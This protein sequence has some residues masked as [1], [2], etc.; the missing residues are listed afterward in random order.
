[1]QSAYWVWIVSR[2]LGKGNNNKGTRAVSVAVSQVFNDMPHVLRLQAFVQTQNKASQRVVEKIGFQRE[3]LLRSYTCLKGK[4]HHVFAYSLLS[5][6]LLPLPQSST[7]I[8]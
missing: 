7:Q 4:I 3:G 5:S 8:V 1:I 6:D 2:V